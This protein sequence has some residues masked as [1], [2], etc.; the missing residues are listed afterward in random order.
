MGDAQNFALMPTNRRI[1]HKLIT[2]PAAQLFTLPLKASGVQ[3]VFKDSS[4]SS[5]QLPS[6]PY[7]NTLSLDLLACHAA[8]SGTQ[9]P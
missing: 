5:S 7:L 2:C 4:P 8:S 9:V 6:F 1:E 3:M